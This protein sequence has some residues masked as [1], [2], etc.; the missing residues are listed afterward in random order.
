MGNLNSACC[1]PMWHTL[2]L[3][4][5][6]YSWLFMTGGSVCSHLLMLVHRS[7]IFLPWRWRRYVP[8]KRQLTQDLHGATSQKTF[9]L[10]SACPQHWTFS[11]AVIDTILHKPI[12]I[13]H[14]QWCYQLSQAQHL[15]SFVLFTAN[16]CMYLWECIRFLCWLCSF[17]TFCIMSKIE[18]VP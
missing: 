5:F 18:T 14:V 2:P 7:Q 11:C 13:A 12:V 3:S 15:V 8:P 16:C 4:L 6:L 1:I 9:F 17:R 10:N